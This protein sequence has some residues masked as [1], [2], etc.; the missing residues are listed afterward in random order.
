MVRKGSAFS[1]FVSVVVVQDLFAWSPWESDVCA[2]TAR[3]QQKYAAIASSAEIL[4]VGTSIILSLRA[5]EVQQKLAYSKKHVGTD[6]L[7]CPAERSS[8]ALRTAVS[9]R[10]TEKGAG[11]SFPNKISNPEA[12]PSLSLRSLQGQGGELD[13]ASSTHGDQNPRSS[14]GAPGAPPGRRRDKSVA[15]SRIKMRKGWAGPQLV[16]SDVIAGASRF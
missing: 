3:L 8:A 14:G 15:P 4:V 9:Y 6:A 10:A 1:P 2:Q 16:W 13:S 12:A 7:V 11:P 5:S